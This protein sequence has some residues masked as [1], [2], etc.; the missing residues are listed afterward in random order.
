MSELEHFISKLPET[1]SDAAKPLNKLVATSFG[2]TVLGDLVS[3]FDT[4]AF[5]H[6]WFWVQMCTGMINQ[7][8]WLILSFLFIYSESKRERI[9]IGISQALGASVGSSLM[10]GYIKPWFVT[11]LNTY[12]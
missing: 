8:T 11:F 9:A 6:D 3:S 7:A 12:K 2:L 4:Y 5:T 1:P 10:L